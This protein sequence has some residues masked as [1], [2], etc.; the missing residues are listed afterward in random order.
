MK[1][2]SSWGSEKWVRRKNYFFGELK[3]G[4]VI[5]DAVGP[6]FEGGGIYFSKFSA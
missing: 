6:K 1:T 5:L 3:S 4:K 2:K